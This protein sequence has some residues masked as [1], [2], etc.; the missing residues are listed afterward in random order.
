MVT[1]S[2]NISKTNNHLSSSLTEHKKGGVMTYN[3]GN[4]GHGLRQ[5]EKWRKYSFI[6]VVF[7]LYF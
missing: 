5:V 3:V 2:T 1:D 7:M 6:R 4:P